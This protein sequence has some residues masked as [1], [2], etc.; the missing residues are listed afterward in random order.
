MTGPNRESRSKGANILFRAKLYENDVSRFRLLPDGLIA[1]RMPRR[2]IRRQ[3][4]GNG[5]LRPE[6]K[7]WRIR[8]P[9]CSRIGKS[10]MVVFSVKRSSLCAFNINGCF[11]IHWSKMTPNREW[12][13]S[14]VLQVLRGN[15]QKLD[16]QD[17]KTKIR[18]SLV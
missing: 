2:A 18:D 8:D 5:S 4:E 3:V 6:P 7:E 9:G 12:S 1:N 11:A 15:G 13:F 16:E 17:L 14:P 10:R